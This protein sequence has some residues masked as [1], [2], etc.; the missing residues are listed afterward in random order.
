MAV[1]MRW[2]ALRG[3][4]EW[5]QTHWQI[6]KEGEMEFGLQVF[7]EMVVGNF[8]QDRSRAHR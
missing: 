7:S 3:R 1:A 8:D 5:A 4:Q 6:Q 2:V